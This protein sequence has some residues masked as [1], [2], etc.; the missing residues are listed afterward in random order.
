MAGVKSIL[1]KYQFAFYAHLQH[2]IHMR[3]AE[4]FS[5]LLCRMKPNE[6]NQPIDGGSIAN[7]ITPKHDLLVAHGRIFTS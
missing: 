3:P 4:F 1:L 6:P 2:A 5:A 7:L